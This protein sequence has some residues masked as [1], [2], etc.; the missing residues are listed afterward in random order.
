MNLNQ[1]IAKHFKDVYFG[2]NWTTVNVKDTLADVTWQQATTQVGNTN[3]IT[4]L[5]YHIHYYF[6]VALKVLQGGALEG[7]DEL[8]F[9]H[10]PITTQKDWDDF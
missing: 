10:P 1:Q 5:A 3:T 2:G 7:K 8:S 4:T 6:R 9:N